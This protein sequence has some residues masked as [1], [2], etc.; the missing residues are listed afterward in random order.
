MLEQLERI[1][2][3]TDDTPSGIDLGDPRIELRSAEEIGAEIEQ[4]L[5]DQD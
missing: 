3:S 5:R 2:D 4:F 1:H